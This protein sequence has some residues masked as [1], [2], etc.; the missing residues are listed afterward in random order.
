MRRKKEKLQISKFRLR[1]PKKTNKRHGFERN[2]WNERKERCSVESKNFTERERETI[3]NNEFQ[4]NKV[5]TPIKTI[6]KKP[7]DEA[8]QK[9]NMKER[10][11]PQKI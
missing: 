6:Q 3:N 1:V 2:K 11:I 8:Y 10:K 9:T 5:E 7:K 4:N